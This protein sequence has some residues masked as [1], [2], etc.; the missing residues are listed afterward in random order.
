MEQQ[1]IHNYLHNFFSLNQCEIKESRQGKITVKLNEELDRLLLNRPFYWEYIK[2]IGQEG[3][4]ATLTFISSPS[5]RHEEG[6]W[7]HFGSPRLHQIFNSQLAQGRYTMLYEQAG[8]TA[9]NPWLVNNIMIS[10]KGRQKKDEILSIGLHLINGTMV[11]NF[12][13]LLKKI[14]FSSVIPDY[15]YTISPIVRIPSAFNRINNYLQHY[16]SEQ[17][18]DW[19]KEA[20]EHFDK[21]KE[22]LNHF[23]ESYTET[24]SDD[25]KELLKERYENEVDH[26]EKRLLPE[27]QIKIINGGLFYLSE[28]TSNQFIGK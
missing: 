12:M 20:Y 11:F 1:A 24:A 5:M 15:S 17:E 10:Y 28:T 7:I 26:L 3:E 13:E 27:I 21:E 2:K 14:S 8:Q 22:I 4:T 16:L 6:E 18:D 23:Y 19:A 9:L 25:E